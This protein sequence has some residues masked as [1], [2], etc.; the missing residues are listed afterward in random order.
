MRSGRKRGPRAARP[1][2]SRGK[3]LV[4]SQPANQKHKFSNA[5]PRTCARHE[6]CTRRRRTEK[7][8]PRPTHAFIGATPEE[9]HL[10]TP[11]SGRPKNPARACGRGTPA[12]TGVARPVSPLRRLPACRPEQLLR[13]SHPPPPR[14][15]RYDVP[16]RRCVLKSPPQS[17]SWFRGRSAAVA[18]R[19]AE[20]ADWDRK[21]SDF[22]KLQRTLVAR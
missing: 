2:P 6:L 4:P 7:T 9:T 21:M 8:P 5:S 22:G 18:A 20:R 12:G 11:S 16:L 13:P 3:P 17:N 15:P 19:S 1:C 14:T 10:A